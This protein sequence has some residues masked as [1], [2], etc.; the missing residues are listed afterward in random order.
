MEKSESYEKQNPNSIGEM[1]GF[2]SGHVETFPNRVYR[3]LASKAA[4]DDIAASG[5]VRSKQSAG[6]DSKYGDK[7]YWGRGGDDKYHNVQ[8]GGYLLEAPY[9]VANDR[10]VTIDD[11]MAIY[12]K[13]EDGELKDILEETLS[14]SLK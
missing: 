4:I 7:V 1:I 14:E 5:L 3:S 11:L 10:E 6:F 2:K 12:H 9:S 13:T 8:T